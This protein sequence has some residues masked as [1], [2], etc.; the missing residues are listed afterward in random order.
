MSCYISSNNNRLYVAL[1]SN[2]GEIGSI[3]EANRIPAVGLD[4]R[5]TPDRVARR[6]KTGSRTF[7]GLPNRIRKNTS[8]RLNTFMTTWA[9]TGQPSCGPLFQAAMGAVPLSWAGGTV[10]TVTGLTQIL[11]SA[12][13]GLSIG[14]GVVWSGE[15]RFVAAIPNASTAIIN[16]PFSNGVG[17]GN[18]L[19]STVTYR[20]ESDLQSASIFDFWDPSTA[21]QRIIQGSAVDVAKIK[22]NGDFHEFE[23]SGPGRDI[24]DSASFVSGQ[25]SLTQF[26][27]EPAQISF[28]YSIVPGHLG[29]V[30]LGAVPVRFYTI[31]DAEIVLENGIDLRNKEFGSDFAQCIAGG[32]RSVRVDLSLLE[33]D[34]AQ[35]KELYQAARQ[36]SPIEMMLQ[37]GEQR[38]QLFGAYMPAMVPEVPE[39]SDSSSRLEWKFASN[40]AQ[41]RSNDELYIAF[42]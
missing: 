23:F 26:P 5:Q 15:I 22:V 40:R 38:G 9:E 20:L 1:E 10:S 34:D 41:G 14:Q 42:G 24:V 32:Q 39:F 28:D 13:H 30:W 2:Y 16:V 27:A 12:P 19:Q 6:D 4:A 25:G 17:S 36:R 8:F 3:T 11:F 31:T 21:V 29:Q 7:V 18:S 33:Q 35:T 37:L